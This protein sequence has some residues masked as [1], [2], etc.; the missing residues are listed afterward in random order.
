MADDPLSEIWKAAMKQYEEETK[1]N[2]KTA[3]AS[4]N[5]ANFS[6]AEE[7]LKAIDD[8][9]KKFVEY[10]KRGAKIKGAL[11]P[12]LDVVGT[13]ASAAGEGVAVVFLPAK[14]IFVA[15]KLLVDM[16]SF[17]LRCRAYVNHDSNI[18]GDLRRKIVNILAHLLLAIGIITK[19]MKRG[20]FK[21]FIR[22]VFTRNSDVQDALAKLDHLTKDEGLAVQAVILQDMREVNLGVRE[23]NEGVKHVN[24][25]HMKNFMTRVL[26]NGFSRI[27]D[28]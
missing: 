15:V 22:G 5:S 12:V 13:L 25:G 6:S 14:A 18:S 1:N 9:Q 7:L 28:L 20:N 21:H 16:Q 10:R 19:D 3:S 24:E 17:L 8:K 26:D 11:G 23:I 27:R 2:L 4:R